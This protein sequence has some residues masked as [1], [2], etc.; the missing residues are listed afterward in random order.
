MEAL[1]ALS[2]AGNIAQFAELGVKLVVTAV[3]LYKDEGI[4]DFAEIEAVN[5]DIQRMMQSIKSNQASTHDTDL[6]ILSQMC[7]DVSI[8]LKTLL[9]GVKIAKRK[10]T[11]SESGSLAK[12]SNSKAKESALRARERAL[13]ARESALKAIKS[14]FQKGKI[15]GLEDRIFRLRDQVCAH[16]AMLMRYEYIVV[17]LVEPTEL[18]TLLERNKNPSQILSIT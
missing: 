7:I 6:E 12:E 18:T 14:H 5:A 9:D 16:V 1:A 11:A 17:Q 2:L 15:K 13:R 8:D 4:P 3:R 10:D